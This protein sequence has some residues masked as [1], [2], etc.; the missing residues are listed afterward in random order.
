MVPSVDAL[1]AGC[2]DALAEHTPVLAVRDVLAE[3]VAAPDIAEALGPVDEGGITSLYNGADLTVL[4][5]TWAPGMV[6]PPHNHNMWAVI[7][8]YGGQEDN[9]F[10][11][12]R[13]GGLERSGGREVGAGEVLVLGDDVIHSVANR[14]SDLAV[15]IHVYG[16]DFFGPG[17]SDWDIDTLVERPFDIER[18]RTLFDEANA[19]WRAGVSS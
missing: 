9:A 6:L 2:Q 15:A 10:Y 8:L 5:V 11:R 4:R 14:R 18:T 17:R 19:R 3:A 13:P 1:V 16:G 7:A 12:R